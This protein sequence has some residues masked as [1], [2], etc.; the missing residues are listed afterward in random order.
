MRPFFS[1]QLDPKHCSSIRGQWAARNS[2]VKSYYWHLDSNLASQWE[3]NE[4]TN[5]LIHSSFWVIIIWT[6]HKAY[7]LKASFPCESHFQTDY[8]TVILRRFK[9]S[10]KLQLLARGR[11]TLTETFRILELFKFQWLDWMAPVLDAIDLNDRNSLYP[12]SRKIEK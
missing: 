10:G 6:Y 5:Q 12:P 9:K 3:P 2:D 1:A 8:D 4:L 7:L 11:H